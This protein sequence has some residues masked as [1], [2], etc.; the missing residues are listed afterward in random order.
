[1]NRSVLTLVRESADTRPVPDSIHP[2]PDM[3]QT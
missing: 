3:K 1:M 2:A